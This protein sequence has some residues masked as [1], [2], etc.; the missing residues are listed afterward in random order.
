MKIY[1]INSSKW[2]THSK[3]WANM[4]G[5]AVAFASFT[6]NNVP[7]AGSATVFYFL[8]IITYVVLP[9]MQSTLSTFTSGTESTSLPVSGA[10]S[11]PP[12]CLELQTAYL[13]MYS[14]VHIYECTISLTVWIT[15]GDIR[16]N[17]D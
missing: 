13:C 8:H 15:R 16:N 5:E 17:M 10:R 4:E 11:C 3:Y 6:F 1:S 9:D 7:T 2:G 12:C 14:F